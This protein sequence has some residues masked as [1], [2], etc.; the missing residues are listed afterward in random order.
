LDQLNKDLEE[1]NAEKAELETNMNN[2]T[3]PY[4]ELTQISKRFA[5]VSALIDEKETRWLELQ[6]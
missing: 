3:L 5:E 6:I 4:D 1:L 2:G